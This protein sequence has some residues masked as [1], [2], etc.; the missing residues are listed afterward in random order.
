MAISDVAV[1]R[2][3][4]NGATTGLFVCMG[5]GGLWIFIGLALW[6]ARP[7]WAMPLAA[8]FA[9]VMAV[10]TVARLGAFRARV[11]AKAQPARPFTGPLYILIVAL[12]V[13][14]IY[15]AVTRLPYD[16]HLQVFAM[17]AIVG[18][19][20]LPLA[21]LFRV[22]AYAVMGLGMMGWTALCLAI[23][24]RVLGGLATGLGMG[25]MFW[26]YAALALIGFNNR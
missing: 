20:F 1:E 2:R 14:A 26:G 17:A 6:S 8:S 18:L 15:G 11:A 5:F 16:S 21:W 7:V 9:A 10:L 25:A 12:E 22:P 13:L 4:A 3:A 19:H 23:P 24:D